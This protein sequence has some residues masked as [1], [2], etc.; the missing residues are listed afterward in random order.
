MVGAEVQ[1]VAS[2]GPMDLPGEVHGQRVYLDLVDGPRDRESGNVRQR[3][4][5]HLGREERRRS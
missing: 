4:I 3:I 5:D 2:S 1:V